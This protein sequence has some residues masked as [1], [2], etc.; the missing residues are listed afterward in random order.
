MLPVY[1]E[2]CLPRKTVYNWAEK[3]FQGGSKIDDE[4]RRGHQILIETKSTERQMEEFSK[5]DSE[6]L[7]EEL[8]LAAL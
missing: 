2:K 6:E 1:G 8:E 7:N 5:N 4:D 3:F